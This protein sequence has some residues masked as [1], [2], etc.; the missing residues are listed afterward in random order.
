MLK[1]CQK[2][3]SKLDSTSALCISKC[4]GDS[5]FLTDGLSATA[6]L[7][8]EGELSPRKPPLNLVGSHVDRKLTW[9]RCTTGGMV[10]CVDHP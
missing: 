6:P 10:L 9:L 7:S 3:W 2:G 1:Q 4:E 5:P 8:L